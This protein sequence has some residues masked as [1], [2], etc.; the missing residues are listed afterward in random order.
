MKAGLVERPVKKPMTIIS[1][2]VAVSLAELDAR[3]VTTREQHGETLQAFHKIWYEAPHTWQI[4][5][6]MGIGIM[7]CPND[8]WMYQQLVVEHRPVAVVET[9]TY[10][11]GSALWFAFLMDMAQVAG[12]RVWTVDVKDYRQCSH[13]RITFLDGDSTDP[14]LV[15]ALAEDLPEAGPRMIV[16]D[17]DHS[18]AHV[19]QEL[20]LFAPLAR[21]GDWVIVEDTNIS[22]GDELGARGGVERYLREH[23]GEFHQDLLCER[24]LLTMSPGGWMQR[25]A[26][27]PAGGG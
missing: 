23:P 22:W 19:Y 10:K 13:P 6:F 9:G 4:T 5:Y 20:C 26:P 11:G 1:D 8:L 17:S 27:C 16:L 12:G 2:D 21:V 15:A 7:K 3:V 14:A 18:T 25:I 24:W